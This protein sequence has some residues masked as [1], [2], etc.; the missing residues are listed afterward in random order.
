VFT[1]I[2]VIIVYGATPKKFV[3][4]ASGVDAASPDNEVICIYAPEF[5]EE[6]LKRR[7]GNG[8]DLESQLATAK[9]RAECCAPLYPV[10]VPTPE[11]DESATLVTYAPVTVTVQVPTPAP[12]K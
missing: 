7:A 3:V 2:R 1:R 10:Y 11:D 4:D 12:E 6:K 9:N 8:R 5:D